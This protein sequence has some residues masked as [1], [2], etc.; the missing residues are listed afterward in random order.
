MPINKNLNIIF[1]HIPKCAGTSLAMSLGMD[2]GPPPRHKK[3]LNILYGIDEKNNIVLQTLPFKYYSNYLDNNFINKAIKITCVRNPYSRAVSD[4]LWSNRNCN[5]FYDFLKLIKKTLE[6]K[7]EDEIIQ[8]N[9][10]HSNHFLPQYK[11]IELNN[12]FDNID[13]ILKIE[14]IDKDFNKKIKNKYPKLKLVHVNKNKSYNYFDY[15]NDKR[16]I[17]LINNIYKKD[18]EIFN[19]EIIKI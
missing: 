15:Y 5:S 7:N 8:Y 3:N 4:Y 19:Y 14:N 2:P 1:I 10:I 16:C 18:F 11:Y 12:Q 13:I 17:E 9:N 6:N